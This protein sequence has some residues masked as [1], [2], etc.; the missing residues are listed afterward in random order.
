MEQ[1]VKISDIGQTKLYESS[2]PIISKKKLLVSAS[3]IELLYYY[4]TSMYAHSCPFVA[5][6]VKLQKL[7]G[8]RPDVS[9]FLTR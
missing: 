3:A 8:S 5:Q 9:Q 6:N 4:E 1:I 2:W 7:R